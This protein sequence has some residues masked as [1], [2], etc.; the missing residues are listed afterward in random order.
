MSDAVLTT[1]APAVDPAEAAA[2]LREHFGLAGE[3]TALAG[4]RDR[5]FRLRTADGRAFVLKMA[6]P[7][8]PAAV[9]NLQT[10]ALIHIAAR[11]RALPV[12]RVVPGLDGAVERVLPFA[13][14]RAMVVRLITY[15]DGEPLH[16]STASPAQA[17]A[18]GRVLGRLDRALGD[19]AH[20]AAERDLLWDATRVTRMR[21]LLAYLPGEE[22][23]DL[24]ARLIDRFEVEAAPVLDGLRRQLIHNDLNPHNVVVDPA[25]H[26][27]IAGII[28]F[29]DA[30]AAPLVADLGTAL[31]YQVEGGDDPLARVRPF[32]AGFAAECPLTAAEIA[33]LPHLILA[34]MMLT[35]CVTHWRAGLAPDNR[36][37]ILR[38]NPGAWRG[39]RALAA[40]PPAALAGDLR[41]ALRD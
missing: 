32:V 16:S 18:L 1:P 5:N 10:A 20:G 2:L 19:F 25:D 33:V 15:L 36:D 4:E 23:R 17:L 9:T 27:R 22:E 13:D 38:N 31:A 41:R 39:L 35:V 12:P 8:E 7:A 14:G 26:A 21:R 37:Y 6:H 29:G 3:V 24:V 28:D 30:L 40:R 34:R 11:D